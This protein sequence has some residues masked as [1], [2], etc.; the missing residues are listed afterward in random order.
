MTERFVLTVDWLKAVCA[1]DRVVACVC[2]CLCLLCVYV[3]VC[4]RGYSMD[5]YEPKIY[6]L[7][8]SRFQQV[9][10]C[11]SALLKGGETP[12]S[13]PHTTVRPNCQGPGHLQ[14]QLC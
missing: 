7:Y 6:A 2:R 8:H 12:T 4:S 10:G 11:Y 3:C 1:D 14:Q 13:W 9:C 5:R